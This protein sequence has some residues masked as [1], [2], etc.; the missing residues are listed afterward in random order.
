MNVR[1][2]TEIAQDII[3][4]TNGGIGKTNWK[5]FKIIITD[6]KKGDDKTR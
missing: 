2:R 1:A 3:V 5:T 4:K 6:D